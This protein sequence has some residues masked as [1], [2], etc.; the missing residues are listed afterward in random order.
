MLK[1]YLDW[2]CINNIERRHPKL[3]WLL[4]EYGEAFIFPYSNAH[5]RDL[6][7][8]H[9]PDNRYFDHDIELLMNGPYPYYLK[10]RILSD[11]GHLS[12]KSSA[13]YL[14]SIIGD[15]T[16]IVILAHLSETNNTPDAALN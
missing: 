1:I 11:R 13:Y 6:M 15:N 8:S 5:I 12:N 2:N 16:K 9:N 10:Q 7:M 14:H 3:Y 4:T